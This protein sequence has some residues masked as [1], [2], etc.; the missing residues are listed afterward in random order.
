MKEKNI[1]ELMK[2]ELS[3]VKDKILVDLDDLN[4]IDDK[5]YLNHLL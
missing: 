1:L 4:N 3:D 5:D 2:K